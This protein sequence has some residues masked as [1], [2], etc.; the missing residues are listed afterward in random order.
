VM[1]LSGRQHVRPLAYT[2]NKQLMSAPTNSMGKYVVKEINFYFSNMYICFA[3]S[4]RGNVSRA[5]VHPP[6]SMVGHIH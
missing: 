6:H 3:I 1:E 4:L 5:T 2:L